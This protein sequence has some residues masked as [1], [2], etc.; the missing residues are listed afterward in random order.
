[1]EKQLM[2]MEFQFNMRL[3]QLEAKT[4]TETQILAE[5]RK[6]N[7]TRIQ[8][9]QQSAMIDQKENKKPSQNFESGQ[10][11]PLSSGIFNR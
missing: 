1:M 9:T 6:D 11:G 5:N 8:A 10:D 4:K 3:K 2:Q 7:R